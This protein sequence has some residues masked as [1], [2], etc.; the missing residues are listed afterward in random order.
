[1]QR[2]HE[3]GTPAD[4]YEYDGLYQ[5]T[6]VWYDTDATE[7]P[8]ITS[9]DAVANYNLDVVY[10]RLRVSFDGSS[11]NYL[12][13]NGLRLT[14]SMN[15]Y[16][17]V[18]ARALSYDPKGNLL[19]DGTN[20]YTYDDENRQI[21]MTGPSGT[22]EYIYD[23]LGRRVA[24]TVGGATTYFVYNTAFQVIEERD[25]GDAL[26]A[27]YTYGAGIDEVLTM[28]RGGATY[29]YHHDALGSVTEAT[30]GAGALVERY[31]YDVYGE[32]SMFDG[33]GTPL[34]ASA[35]SNPY[36]FTGRRHDPE[37]ANYYYRARMYSPELG[38]FLQMDPLGYVDGMN[39]YA[40]TNNSPVSRVDPSGHDA[41]AACRSECDEGRRPLMEKLDEARRANLVRC[42]QDCRR[43][44]P[45]PSTRL[46]DCLG[47]CREA[48]YEDLSSD[49]D[50]AHRAVEYCRRRCAN[51][52]SCPTR[53]KKPPE[54][55]APN[56]ERD[57]EELDDELL[58]DL[59][60]AYEIEGGDRWL[61]SAANPL[62]DFEERE[63]FWHN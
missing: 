13:N 14:N 38:R 63:P 46:T 29:T 39:A 60:E 26:A 49:T 47:D 54:E 12:P 9:R 30:D 33:T 57:W 16:D 27:R 50:W 48:D 10:N 56:V 21:T 58:D 3:S 7:P 62:R 44:F 41:V 51:N 8:A 24:R 34:A 31:T 52:P 55:P 42:L 17:Q 53:P 35:I 32:P 5:L 37:S 20:T 59:D 23:A 4:V 28:E 6:R 22:A 1:M 43:V 19:S 18:G 45:Y 15:R 2:G 36:L 25:A 40:Y 61:P 11:E